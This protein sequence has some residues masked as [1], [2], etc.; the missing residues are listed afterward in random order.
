MLRGLNVLIADD[1]PEILQVVADLLRRK[2]HVVLC[3]K[4]GEEALRMAT[5][6]P[7]DAAVLDIDMPIKTGLEVARA[8]R[9]SP[10][11]AHVRLIAMTGSVALGLDERCVEAGFDRICRKP[12]SAPTLLEALDDGPACSFPRRNG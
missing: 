6:E 7:L 5:A 2:G 8:M 12:F 9:D 10:R 1:Q 4:D 11:T 3:A